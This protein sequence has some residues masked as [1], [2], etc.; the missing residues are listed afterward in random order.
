MSRVGA[1]ARGGGARGGAHTGGEDAGPAPARELRAG[2]RG[3]A[4]VQF[5]GLLETVPS[6]EE[7]ANAE[8]TLS[9][10]DGCAGLRAPGFR[11]P[12][13]AGPPLQNLARFAARFCHAGAAEPRWEL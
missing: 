12:P 10:R 9:P 2:L 6:A 4:P 8:Y 1:R 11:P 13:G 5:S 3:F 7:Y